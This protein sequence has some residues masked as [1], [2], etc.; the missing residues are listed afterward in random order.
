MPVKF[1]PN[2]M[3]QTT[4][5]FELFAKNWIIYIHFWQKFDAI[6]ENVSVA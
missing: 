6:L 1:E 5:N 4:R 2:R 3:V